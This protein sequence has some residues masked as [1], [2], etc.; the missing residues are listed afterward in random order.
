MLGGDAFFTTNTYIIWSILPQ[1]IVVLDKKDTLIHL[2]V[3]YDHIVPY[4]TDMYFDNSTLFFNTPAVK[5]EYCKTIGSICYNLQILVGN[6]K[7]TPNFVP[8]TP[9]FMG[10]LL[11]TIGVLKTKQELSFKFFIC[12]AQNMKTPEV[13]GSIKK[14]QEK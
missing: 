2:F 6:V 9:N 4:E 1:T 13:Y 11:R 7:Q 10:I 5:W 12:M 14:K 3:K 8:K